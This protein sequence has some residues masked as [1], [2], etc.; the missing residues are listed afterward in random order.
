[1][2]YFLCDCITFIGYYACTLC[3]SVAFAHSTALS[4]QALC[5]FLVVVLGPLTAEFD[6]DNLGH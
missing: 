2:T 6:P 4:L 1:M 5:F 3:F